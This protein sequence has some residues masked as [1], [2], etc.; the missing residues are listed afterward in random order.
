MPCAYNVSAL[1]TVSYE[2]GTDLKDRIGAVKERRI[3]G[4]GTPLSGVDGADARAIQ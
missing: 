3:A 4:G 2:C 1:S